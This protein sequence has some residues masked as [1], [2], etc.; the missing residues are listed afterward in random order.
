VV[1][2]AVTA[3]N[4][5]EKPGQEMKSNLGKLGQQA[6][7]IGK[8]HERD[9]GHRGP[10]QPPGPER[11]H[12]GGPGRGRRTRVRRGGRRGAQAGRKDHERHQGSGRAIS[13]IQEGTRSQYPGHGAGRER[14]RGG[15][16]LANSPGRP[17]RKSCALAE[18]A[19][20]QVRSIATAAEEQSATSEEINRSVEDINRISSETSEVMDQSAQAIS[21]LARQAVELQELVQRILGVKKRDDILPG[22]YLLHVARQGRR[23][24]HVVVFRQR[25]GQIIDVLRILHDSMIWCNI[26]TPENR[27]ANPHACRQFVWG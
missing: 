1:S 18:Q 4:T 12:R 21:E 6:E 20:D 17:A 19:A 24:R 23:G 3:I 16:Q 14:H 9:R 15:H 27:I 26:W 25:P 10:D 11:G 13:A 8:D 22:I 5:V 7:Q 2:E